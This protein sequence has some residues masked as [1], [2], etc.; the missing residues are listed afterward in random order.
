VDHVT[1]SILAGLLGMAA[2]VGCSV[3]QADA[4]G[5]GAEKRVPGRRYLRSVC[6]HS[7][8]GGFRPH[9]RNWVHVA[10]ATTARA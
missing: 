8:Q 3:S 10:V 6:S 1:W 9:V 7:M 2:V 4:Y 5:S